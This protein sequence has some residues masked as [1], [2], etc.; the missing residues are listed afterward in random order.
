M[1]IKANGYTPQ[2]D[3]IIVDA[4]S[5]C[6]SNLAACFANVAQQLGRPISGVNFRWYSYLK[7]QQGVFNL[8]DSKHNHTNVKNQPRKM[9]GLAVSSVD[10]RTRFIPVDDHVMIKVSYE[11]VPND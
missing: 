7:K 9:N 4:V 8:K 6:S 10:L 3:Q 2:E 5:K 1:R 11:L